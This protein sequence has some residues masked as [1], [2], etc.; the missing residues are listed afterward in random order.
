MWPYS[1]CFWHRVH[2]QRLFSARLLHVQDPAVADVNARTQEA[3]QV[4]RLGPRSRRRRCPFEA[5]HAE[6]SILLPSRRRL[7]LVQGTLL[8][9]LRRRAPALSRAPVGSSS[10]LLV[11]S[12]PRA[13]IRDFKAAPAA[14]AVVM[15]QP[16]Q[17][18]PY[19]SCYLSTAELLERVDAA[20]VNVRAHS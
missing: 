10:A 17:L 20:T 3:V 6:A 2:L 16:Q 7:R 4:P 9:G 13:W 1:R 5:G 18:Q 19:S 8:E 15:K 11:P 12:R 14:A